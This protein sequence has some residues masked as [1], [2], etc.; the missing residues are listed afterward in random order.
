MARR[1]NINDIVGTKHNR[2]TILGETDAYITPSG[3]KYRAV[4]V[5][6]IC[7]V[8]KKAGMSAVISGNTKSCGCLDKQ[9]AS[10][11]LKKRM[12]T[13]GMKKSSEYNSWKGMKMRCVNQNDTSYKNYGARGITVCDRWLN[14]FENFLADMGKKPSTKHSIERIDVN[15]NYEPLNCKWADAKEQGLNK[16]N[17]VVLT[18]NGITKPI[19]QWAKDIGISHSGLQWRIDNNYTDDRL[20]KK[21]KKKNMA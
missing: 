15:G 5:E 19:G 20:I 6:C 9:A 12:T 10:N 18:I 16:R 14:S 4:L 11:R 17:S 13:H 7:G 1:V 2:L 8:I 3:N 21:S